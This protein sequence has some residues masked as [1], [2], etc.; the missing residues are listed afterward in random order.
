MEQEIARVV[1]EWRAGIYMFPT[2]S[3]EPSIVA[4]M[5][6]DFTQYLGE[7]EEKE[8]TFC[9][10]QPCVWLSNHESM[11]AWDRVGPPVGEPICD[12]DVWPSPVILV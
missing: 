11:Q 6:Q 9:K 4:N 5:E 10:E 7:R 2:T 8:C 12:M 3:S 1:G